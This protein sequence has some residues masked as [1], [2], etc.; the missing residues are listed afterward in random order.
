MHNSALMGHLEGVAELHLG[1]AGDI[2][3]HQANPFNMRR[4]KARQKSTPSLES[5]SLSVQVQ[6]HVVLIA[7][8]VLAVLTCVEQPLKTLGSF[9]TKPANKT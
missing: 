6:Y 3:P 1:V 5:L 8:R 4:Q 2:H 9:T 7:S